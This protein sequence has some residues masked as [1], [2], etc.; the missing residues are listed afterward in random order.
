M[1]HSIKRGR[2]AASRGAGGGAV[3]MAALSLPGVWLAPAHAETAPEKGVIAF[4]YL[5]YEDSQPGFD[6]IRVNSPSLYLM[7]PIGSQWSIEGSAVIDSVS[8]ATPRWQT[9]VSSASVM[10]EERK[11]ADIKVTRYFNRSSYSLGVSTSH[12]HDYVSNALSLGGSWSS[13]DNNT[14][15]NVGIGGSA[16]Q[17]NPTDGGV[18]NVSGKTKQT[19]ELIAGV[20]Q[21]LSSNDLVQVNLTYGAGHG[22]YDDPYK[23]LD[24]RPDRREQAAL[25][26]RWNHY[27]V[28][29]QSTLRATYRFYRDSY[30]ITA[31]TV[32]G[33][34]AKPVSET[35]ILTPAIRLYTQSAANFYATAL[36][37]E[38][39]RPVLP[40][41]PPG[42]LN[43]GDQRL[44]AFGAV[45]LSLKAEY[46]L[47]ALWTVDAKFEAYE[48]RANWRVG[49]AGSTGLDPFRARA[50]QLGA[51]RKF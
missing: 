44:S 19:G 11:A 16:D 9:A 6:R 39:G 40:D 10:H 41:P 49:G 35:L 18:P 12:E 47:S 23:L 51:S 13:D 27:L 48:Q 28:G 1:K 14:T 30:G 21:A 45:G 17:I 38:N 5:H 46:R 22:Y 42:Q 32:Q 50:V 15:W 2:P 37:D 20:T 7:T 24:T 3:V 8:G 29:D 34:W 25:L 4:K 33:E 43:S 36:N 26:G 31:H